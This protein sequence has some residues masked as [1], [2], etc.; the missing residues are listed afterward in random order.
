M[1]KI[2]GFYLYNDENGYLSNWYPCEFE[3]G[4][5]TYSSAEQFMMAQKAM[6]FRDFVTHREIMNTSDQSVIKALGKQVHN[7]DNWTWDQERGHIMHCG[8][9]A[10]FQQNAELMQKLL[11]TGNMVLAECSPRDK[12]WGIGLAANDERIHDPRNW[13]GKNLLG[14]TLMKVRADL[15]QWLAVSPENIKYVNAFDLPANEIWNMPFQLVNQLPGMKEAIEVY[16]RVVHYNL[17][18]N[19]YLYQRY[20]GSLADLEYSMRTNMGGG[21]PVAWFYEMKQEIYD[22]VRFGG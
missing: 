6:V 7:Y 16:G 9:R 10:K 18:G 20:K 5:F 8:L 21:L 22:L 17:Q 12:V 1:D 2:L 14:D 15:R 4:Q 19:D 11:D 3:Y 13:K